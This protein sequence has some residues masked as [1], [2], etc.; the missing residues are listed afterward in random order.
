MDLSLLI[1]FFAVVCLP[2]SQPRAVTHRKDLPGDEE[3]YDETNYISK[4]PSA[5]DYNTKAVKLNSYYHPYGL[6]TLGRGN[7]F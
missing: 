5:E 7:I 3:D 2:I 4:K 6:D 1:L